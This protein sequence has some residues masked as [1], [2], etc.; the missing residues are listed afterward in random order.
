MW[1]VYAV[2]V[3]PILIFSIRHPGALLGRFTIVTY[4]NSELGL[5]ETVW[6]FA[7]HYVRNLN[8]WR[9]LVRGDPSRDQ[10]VHAFGPPH[11]LAAVF[12]FSVTGILLLIRRAKKE[13]W[14]RFLL[15]G[16]A[17]AIV[18]ASLTH[19]TFHMLR[20][21]AVP[22]FLLVFAIEGGAWFVAQSNRRL[23]RFAFIALLALAALESGWFQWHRS[24][25]RRVGR[26]CRSRWS[27]Y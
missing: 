9:L 23:W 1:D 17:V 5:G 11:F 4:L 2:L 16:I 25:E 20:L 24:E 13:A 14:A 27:P 10:I 26:E 15:Y 6:Q 21:I 8:P 22:V 3:S 7:K 18:P 12:V 19:E